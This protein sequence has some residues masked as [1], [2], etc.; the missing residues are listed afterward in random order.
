MVS[1]HGLSMPAQ[2]GFIT[3]MTNQPLWTTDADG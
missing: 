1:G 2:L 3:G